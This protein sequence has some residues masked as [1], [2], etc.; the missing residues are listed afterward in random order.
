MIQIRVKFIDIFSHR[1]RPKSVLFNTTRYRFAANEF[2]DTVRLG[3][4]ARGDRVLIEG[5]ARFADIDG[6]RQGTVACG[7]VT[8]CA[9]SVTMCEFEGLASEQ[10]KAPFRLASFRVAPSCATVA[11][12]H[13]VPELWHLSRGH[14]RAVVDGRSIELKTG[15]VVQFGPRVRHQ[16]HNVGNEAIE[17]V[18][19]WWE[20]PPS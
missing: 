17:A 19:I 7:P 3:L 11:E 8:T 15:D 9:I 13:D 20:V 5:S 14:G 1:D 16:L 2:C 4:D 18:S 6:I 10:P 12:A